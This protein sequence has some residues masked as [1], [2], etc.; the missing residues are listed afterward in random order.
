M[1]T[2][3]VAVVVDEEIAADFDQIGE[4][5]DQGIPAHL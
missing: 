5:I 4:K 3:L 1:H 2:A